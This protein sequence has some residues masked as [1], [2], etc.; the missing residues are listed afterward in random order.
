M[1]A[2]DGSSLGP[3]LQLGLLGVCL[4]RPAV[5]GGLATADGRRLRK[6]PRGGGHQG[7]GGAKCWPWAALAVCNCCWPMPYMPTG[8]CWRWL[9]YAAGH[10]RPGGLAV[11][12]LALPRCAGL[13]A[14]RPVGRWTQHSYVRTVQGHKQRRVVGSDLG[15][16]PDEVQDSF[17]AAAATHGA[18]G[19]SLWCCL[20]RE[21]EPQ[22][23]PV[24]EA[25]A[26]VSTQ[27]WPDGFAALLAYRPRW[28]VEDDSYRELK[29]GWG[30]EEQRWGRDEAAARGRGDADVS[31]VQH[32]ISVSQSGGPAA[33]AKDP[34][35]ATR[36]LN[37]SWGRRWW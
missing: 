4:G 9:K 8:R 3:G 29:E 10:R 34:S 21:R 37:G 15:G 12:P 28:H 36:M 18:A 1:Y 35:V 20:I 5:A 14:W 26:L 6:G 24:A 22:S 31:G 30:L 17:T 16:R 23:W 27:R 33:G 32:G 11:G 13:G 7:T 2:V 25:E 19:A